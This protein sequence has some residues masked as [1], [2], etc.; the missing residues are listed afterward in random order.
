[1][2]WIGPTGRWQTAAYLL[3]GVTLG[4]FK[5]VLEHLFVHPRPNA[6]SLSAV[7]IVQEKKFSQSAIL[8]PIHPNCSNTSLPYRAVCKDYSKV[9]YMKC[10]EPSK[11][12]INA[13]FVG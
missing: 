3:L 9:T 10:L 5:V 1:M 6:T 4:S 11:L 2:A 7:L 8:S 13:L 12:C